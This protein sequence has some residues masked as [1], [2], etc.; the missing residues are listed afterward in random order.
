MDRSRRRKPLV[1]RG[2]RQVG[3]STLVRQFAAKFVF[4]KRVNLAVRFDLNPPSVQNVKNVIQTKEGN[5][6][7]E[8]TLV[9]LPLYMV[10]EL[11]RILDDLRREK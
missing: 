8:Y 4:R 2:A 6:E 10:E 1:L 5:H 11:P 9:S 7:V 3:K